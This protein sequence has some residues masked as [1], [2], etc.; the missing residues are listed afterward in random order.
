MVGPGPQAERSAALERFEAGDYARAAPLLV[1]LLA[2]VPPDVVLL[3]ACGMALTR[4][5]AVERG[6]PYLARARRMAPRDALS[7]MWHGIAL[8]SAGRFADAAAALRQAS[9]LSPD[10]AAVLVHLC[11]AL[12][13]TGR[14][15]EAVGTAARAVAIAPALPEAL[16][17]LR[18]AELSLLNAASSGPD[19]PTAADHAAGWTRFGETCLL[20]DSIDEARGAFGQA[21]AL[22]PD[23]DAAT[24]SLALV[25]HV[26]GEPLGALERLRALLARRPGMAAARLHLAGR[27]LLHDEA[28][29]AL[30]LL[31]AQPD[32]PALG[33]RWHATRSDALLRLGRP[34]QAA[35]AL[36]QTSGATG[37]AEILV[38]RQAFQLARQAGAASSLPRLV[39]RLAELA[40]VRGAPLIEDRIDAQFLLGEFHHAASRHDLAFAHWWRGHAL[41]RLAQ[42]FSRDR[43]AA[44]LDGIR[45]DYGEARFGSGA[46]SGNADP[47]P[48]FIVGLPRTGTT[49]AEHIL[50]AHGA[51][52]GAGERLAVRETLRRLTRSDE[53]GTA[54]GI[55]AGLDR[56]TLNGAADAYLTDLHLL[57]PE[58]RIVVDKM[59]D[60]ASCLGF[61]AT[62]LP[63]AKAIWCRRD[64]RDVG[65]SIYRQRFLGHH[66][67][68]HDLEDLGWFMRR[69][70]DLMRHW[71]AVR[72]LPILE[73]DHADWIRD[74]PGT[75]ARV[76]AFLDLPDDPACLAFHRQ[77]R[78]VRTASREQVR[79]PVN[80]DGVGGW[81]NY[82][83]QLA[84]MLAMLERDAA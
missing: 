63:G 66:P 43:H 10:D 50:S 37:D 45:R 39:H 44:L 79:R 21:L 83:A 26:C 82:A 1:A 15:G 38:C 9:T 3:R 53:L 54:L 73:L 19:G 52:H 27:L 4:A 64:L 20:L 67:Y 31:G 23:D 76:L 13:K 51:V 29:Q 70:E 16:H 81:R 58:A 72:A 18:L 42:P 56:T 59:P 11:R 62:L 35:R 8:Q 48:L 49:L 12:L 68:A 28:E 46:V 30:T 55:A 47:A 32:Q 7:A 41:L 24:L 65:A 2:R 34:D 84:P 69:Q 57:A 75:L 14:E 40:C 77:D 33:R 36:E 80:A 17:A 78:A 25:E 60:N 22:V 6:L 5:G 61:I 71:Q 74:F